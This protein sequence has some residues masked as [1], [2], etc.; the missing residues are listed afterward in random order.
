[1]SPLQVETTVLPHPLTHDD[2]TAVCADDIFVGCVEVKAIEDPISGEIVKDEI[3]VL[4]PLELDEDPLYYYPPSMSLSTPDAAKMSDSDSSDSDSDDEED[5]DDFDDALVIT[6]HHAMTS[7]STQ[8]TKGVDPE[9]YSFMEELL[10]TLDTIFGCNYGV[11][12]DTQEPL[13]VLKS[14]LRR[15]GLEQPK[16]NRNVSWTKL[17]IKEFN[18]TLGN[19][20]SAVTVRDMM[21]CSWCLSCFLLLG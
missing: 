16:I 7:T 18:M 17:E 2:M 5:D 9:T 20:P 14:A 21:C 4:V 8:P 19:H 6:N 13:P 1:M 11:C 12:G 10:Q 15:K 3:T